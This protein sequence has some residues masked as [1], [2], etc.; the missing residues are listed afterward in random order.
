MLVA[1]G[2]HSEPYFSEGARDLA[3]VLPQVTVET[4]SG[5]DHA[6]LWMAAE[7]IVA[8]ARRFFLTN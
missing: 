3:E 5:Q 8:S 6:A 4:L 1:I 2:E 7:V